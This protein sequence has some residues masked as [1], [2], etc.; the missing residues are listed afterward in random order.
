MQIGTTAALNENSWILLDDLFYAAMLPSG[1][2]AAYLLAEIFGFF[3][4]AERKSI[5]CLPS[6]D[7][8]DLTM[9][10]NTNL[11]FAEFLKEMNAT[12]SKLKMYNTR[13]SNPHGLPNAM[14][15]SSARDMITLSRYATQN[16]KFKTIMNTIS[17]EY[18]EFDS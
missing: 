1:N 12:S 8:I 16:T 5:K 3:L 11:Y 13:F 7:R 4:F 15:L 2:D 18:P 14:N 10:S 9:E 17:H 6:V